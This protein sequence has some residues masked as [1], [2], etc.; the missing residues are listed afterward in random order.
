[1]NNSRANSAADLGSGSVGR[2]IVKLAFPAIIAQMVNLLYNLV[3]RIYI[4]HIPVVGDIALTGLGL[5][6][7]IL[8]IVTAFSMLVGA[9]GAPRASIAMGKGESDLAQKILGNCTAML[10][11]LSLVLTV[12]L[13]IFAEPLLLLFG[14]SENTLPFALDYLRIYLA[15]N[16][17]VMIALGLNTFITA[18]GFAKI[19]MATVIIGAVLNI[20][21]DPLFIFVFD[22]GVRGAALATIISQAV[23]ALWVLLF[24]T[25]KKTALKIKRSDLPI[26]AKVIFPVLALGVSP[27]I[28]TATESI[29]NIAFNS[30]LS[31]YGDDVAVGAMTILA[32]IMQLMM[33]PTQGLAQGTQPIVSYNYGAGKTDRVRKAYRILFVCCF[34]YTFIFWCFVQVF[35]EFFVRLFN[36]E[37]AELLETTV[38]ALRIYL[39]AMGFFGIQMAAQQTFVA[40]GQAKI[41]LF[42]ASLRKII[43]LIPLIYILPNFFEDKVF[44]VFLAEPVADAISIIAAGSLFFFSIK[45]ILS[46][47]PNKTAQ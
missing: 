2:L 28:M 12:L 44:A 43:L 15:G 29:L 16:I 37:S 21:L 5:C 34:A 47:A 41:S 4:G 45:K 33:M 17:F 32:S 24:L 3:D 10:V 38:G 22:M 25:G 19:S 14:A 1:M 46:K 42:I 39:A 7:P 35:P 26:R 9:G 13:E 27:F 40:L 18:Q 31:K 20:A 8:M 36:S 11:I 30:S 6:F 23:S